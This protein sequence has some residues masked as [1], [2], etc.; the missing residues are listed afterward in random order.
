MK[1]VILC[2]TSHTQ[3]SGQGAARGKERVVV[4]N[5]GFNVLWS[6][7]TLPFIHPLVTSHLSLQGSKGE[8]RVY[9]MGLGMLMVPRH[10]PSGAGD[11]GLGGKERAGRVQSFGSGLASCAQGKRGHLLMP[12]P[13][14]QHHG[15]QASV[16][17]GTVTLS[18]GVAVPSS[19]H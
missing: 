17:W 12:E 6:R 11:T 16:P 2:V 1:P 8:R 19:H 14:T 18:M 4:K 5:I 7:G 10:L 9:G 15:T 13:S 3:I